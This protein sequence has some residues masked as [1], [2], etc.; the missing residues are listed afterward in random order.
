M[1]CAAPLDAFQGNVELHD[2]LSVAMLV[3]APAELG[4]SIF[5]DTRFLIRGGGG[6]GAAARSAAR[7]FSRLNTLPPLSKPVPPRRSGPALTET[8]AA[9]A[10]A[11]AADADAAAAASTGRSAAPLQTPLEAV[12]MPFGCGTLAA[13]APSSAGPSRPSAF[14]WLAERCMTPSVVCRRERPDSAAGDGFG[15]SA[16]PPRAG[17]GGVSGEGMSSMRRSSGK[18]SMGRETVAAAGPREADAAGVPARLKAEGLRAEGV[19]AA[20]AGAAAGASA[21]PA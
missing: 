5:H 4:A 21:L 1:H 9:A 2:R 19:A 3:A 14:R 8:D 7:Q 20:A 16:P 17:L 12:R 18:G 10:A 15:S 6:G 13:A 11:A